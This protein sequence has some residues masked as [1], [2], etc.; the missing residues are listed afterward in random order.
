MLESGSFHS[1]T[2]RRPI[3]ARHNPVA[4]LQRF[5]DLADVLIAPERHLKGCAVLS[6]DFGEVFFYRMGRALGILA[7]LTSTLRAGPV[8]MIHGAAQSHS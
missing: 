8:E 5:Q 3:Q 6:A 2:R 4:L 1:K 7:S